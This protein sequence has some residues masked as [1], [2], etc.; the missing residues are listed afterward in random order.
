ML[1]RV[2]A[3]SALISSYTVTLAN[4]GLSYPN[5]LLPLLY[6]NAEYLDILVGD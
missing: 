3:V 2:V 1:S 6:L 5:M 4:I